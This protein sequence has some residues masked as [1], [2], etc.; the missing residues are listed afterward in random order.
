MNHLSK[1]LISEI[2]ESLSS[3]SRANLSPGS[4]TVTVSECI[5]WHALSAL[6]FPDKKNSS[7]FT[8]FKYKFIQNASDP[9]SDM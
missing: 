9:S 4:S 3:D 8:T 5:E 1:W 2:A 7:L 6:Q